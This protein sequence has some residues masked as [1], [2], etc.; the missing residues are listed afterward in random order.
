MSAVVWTVIAAVFQ[1]A[2]LTLQGMAAKT[3]AS[4]AAKAAQSKSISDAVASQD[5]SQINSAIQQLR[6]K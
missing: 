4:N 5:V 1:I 2:L 6:E 3:A